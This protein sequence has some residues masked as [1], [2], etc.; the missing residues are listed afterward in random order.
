MPDAVSALPPA[1]LQVVDTYWAHFLGC[2]PAALRALQPTTIRRTA[3]PD[4]VA[5]RTT[6][7][8]TISM[9]DRAMR[10]IDAGALQGLLE[11]LP[12]DGRHDTEL[13]TSLDRAGLPGIHGPARLHY[14]TPALFRPAP[15]VPFR[16]LT[17]IDHAEFERFTA[18]MG[19]YVDYL[20][21]DPRF[22]Y[23]IGSFVEGVLASVGAVQ[24]W[25]GL[26]AE[27]YGDTLPEYR[28]HGLARGLVSELTRWILDETPYIA[29]EDG[30]RANTASM[31][32]GE[33]LGYV[34]Y[35][36]LVMN[37]LSLEFERE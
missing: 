13:A 16:R 24:V 14:V 20:L 11:R 5:L 31:R 10:R 28:G 9:S 2:S 3:G 15:A 1:V 8:W 19:G 32:I 21:D 4:L 36:T 29:Q 22:P 35:G 37:N 18:G 6:G 7:A 26:L 27:T 17:A 33:R 34:P 12:E 23:V 30:I 25:G